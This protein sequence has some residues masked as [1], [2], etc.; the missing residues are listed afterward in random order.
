MT[1]FF[2]DAKTKTNGREEGKEL[3]RQIR[4]APKEIKIHKKGEKKEK[5]RK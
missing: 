2:G 1:C 3:Y 4:E 5:V